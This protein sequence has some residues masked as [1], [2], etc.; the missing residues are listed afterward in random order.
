MVRLSPLDVELQRGRECLGHMQDQAAAGPLRRPG[1]VVHHWSHACQTMGVDAG[2]HRRG[3]LVGT[4][5][6]AVL[7]V[8]RTFVSSRLSAVYLA[9]AYAQVVPTYRRRTR[10]TDGYKVPIDEVTWQRAAGEGRGIRDV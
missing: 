3:H 6:T 9:A 5:A 2:S 4:T 10:L 1:A 7:E 8:R